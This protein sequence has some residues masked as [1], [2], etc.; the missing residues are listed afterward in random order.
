M[1]KLEKS[2]SPLTMASSI[3][4]IDSVRADVAR[5]LLRC[6]SEHCESY[7]ILT[8]YEDMPEKFGSDIDFMINRHD[9]NRMPQLI[10]DLAEETGTVLFQ[11]I[12]HEVSAR[13]FRL[14]AD[15]SG[16]FSFIQPDSC[17]DYR[18]FGKIWLR[19]EEML[20]SRRWHANGFW[21]PG[22]AYEFTYYLIKRI[23]KRDVS[24]EHCDRLSTLYA[25]DKPGCDRLL[26][27]FWA[28]Q[29][30][31]GI[32]DMAATGKW[33]Q[34]LANIERFR[35][36]LRKHA[37][38]GMPQRI[39]SY[40]DD[41][42]HTIQRILHPTG[43]WVAFIG[44]DGCGKSSVIE[45]VIAQLGPG[46]QKVVRYHLRP[47]S[48]PARPVSEAA[49]TDPHNQA[50]RGVALSIAKMFYLA[51]DYWMGYL[52]GTRQATMR[53]QLVVFDRYFYD[54]LVD[55]KRVRY[56]GPAWL[57]RALSHILPKPD[58]VLVLN[59]AP[60]VLWSRKQEVPYQEVVR[61]QEEY[62]RVADGLNSVAVID[63]AQPL[64]QVV[65][66]A[67]D[68]IVRHVS[69]RTC[70]RLSVTG[71]RSSLALQ[72]EVQKNDQVR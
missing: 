49:V 24:Q 36:E 66:S 50:P 14:V 67:C 18:H 9:F 70:K 29:T 52:A 59:A 32:G 21:I 40:F 25:E 44:P 4:T 54:I 63:A 22:A 58:L 16:S 31:Q 13:A 72:G 10:R 39:R 33:D 2:D 62:L 27:R 37:V 65:Q 5:R 1:P 23:N 6:L 15:D 30:A 60:E 43:A 28:R 51:F 38:G 17:A 55:P 53:T 7:C 8:G 64:S 69:S 57:P 41:I 20:A 12:Q 48:L 3:A 35:R 26:R 61:Q 34:L 71:P 56:D 45:G 42:R 19:S 11:A 46:F 68:A 47:K